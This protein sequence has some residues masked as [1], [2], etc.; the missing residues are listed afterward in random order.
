MPFTWTAPSSSLMSPHTTVPLVKYALGT[1]ASF[2]SLKQIDFCLESCH[3]PLLVPFVIKISAQKKILQKDL[4]W[5][6]NLKFSPPITLLHHSLIFFIVLSTI[7]IFC[8]FIVYWM[9]PPTNCK[10]LRIGSLCCR[11]YI[12]SQI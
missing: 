4:P 11:C 1:L 2:Y 3:L 10:L 5:P 8:S 7:G 12:I 6:S 9:S